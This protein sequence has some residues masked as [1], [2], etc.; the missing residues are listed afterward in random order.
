MAMRTERLRRCLPSLWLGILLCIAAIAAPAVFAS[1]EKVDAGRVVA[2][3]FVQEAW[4]SLGLAVLLLSIERARAR[5]AAEAGQGSVFSTEM[6]M[7]LGTVFCTVAG[8]FAI[9][10]MLPAARAGLGP[11]SFGQL[12]AVSSGFYGLKMMLVL[13]LSW[14]A[15]RA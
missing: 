13:V 3:I 14:R 10:P 2:R 4:M 8:Y 1:L 6:L 12:H 5:M 15:T 11:M 9:Q 7:L